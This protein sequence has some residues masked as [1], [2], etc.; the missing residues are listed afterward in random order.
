[1]RITQ[2]ENSLGKSFHPFKSESGLI[3]SPLKP[4]SM[5]EQPRSAFLACPV[6]FLTAKRLAEVQAWGEAA[7][8]VW[9]SD[10]VAVLLS[11]WMLQLVSDLED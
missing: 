11:P 9:V 3:A 7:E 2:S 5:G 6:G 4:P 1:M 10:L 8:L